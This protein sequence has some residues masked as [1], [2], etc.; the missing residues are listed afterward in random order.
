MLSLLLKMILNLL[1]LILFHHQLVFGLNSDD[2]K[3]K[4]IKIILNSSSANLMNSTTITSV[5]F[6]NE[7]YP[8]ETII[9]Y[10]VQVIIYT[11][12]L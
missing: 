6:P 12:I 8:P 4:N 1:L 2:D 11:S 9:N 3:G 5:G 7:L 10:D